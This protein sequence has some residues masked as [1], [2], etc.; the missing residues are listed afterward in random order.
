MCL[1]AVF[2][3]IEKRTCPQ[4]WVGKGGRKHRTAGKAPN[5]ACLLYFIFSFSLPLY[6]LAL[7]YPGG[8]L[9]DQAWVA[10]WL[11]LAVDGWVAPPPA[12]PQTEYTCEV[13]GRKLNGVFRY[14]AFAHS[15][16]LRGSLRPGKVTYTWARMP[17][18]N[19]TLTHFVQASYR[20]IQTEVSGRDVLSSHALLNHCLVLLAVYILLLPTSKPHPSALE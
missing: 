2:D 3:F 13:K 19:Q 10:G 18:L 16:A 15:P 4:K 12:I 6:D 8:R 20:V 1:I 14:Q 17:V 9:L 7:I 11:P 5:W